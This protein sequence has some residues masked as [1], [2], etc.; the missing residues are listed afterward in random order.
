MFGS[1]FAHT[2]NST[3]NINYAQRKQTILGGQ[4]HSPP[5]C[6]PH[7]VFH[8][9]RWTCLCRVMFLFLIS[10]FHFLSHNSLSPFDSLRSA[11]SRLC[12]SILVYSALMCHAL[13]LPACYS[14]YA[15]F[16]LALLVGCGFDCV[17]SW[18]SA[19]CWTGPQSKNWDLSWTLQS[20]SH[21][22]W[23]LAWV[24]ARCDLALLHRSLKMHMTNPTGL[25]RSPFPSLHVFFFLSN[26]PML[27][28]SIFFFY[29]SNSLRTQQLW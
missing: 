9:V 23:T 12:G 20:V 26:L 18:L 16:R 29:Q 1:I 19:V 2:K 15:P 4:F 14:A 17:W 5:H 21:F 8:T 11:S 28:F 10:L 6:I 7:N 3:K 27:L 13:F 25:S 22:V 24:S